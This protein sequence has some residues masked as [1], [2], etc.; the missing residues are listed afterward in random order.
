MFKSISPRRLQRLLPL[1]FVWLLWSL[2]PVLVWGQESTNVA[3]FD[4]LNSRLGAAAE[5]LLADTYPSTPTTGALAS[6]S[7]VHGMNAAPAARE[8]AISQGTPAPIASPRQH[9]A[10]GPERRG[11]SGSRVQQLRP[12]IDPI[13]RGEGI[14]ADFVAVALIESGGQAAALSPKGARGVWQLMPDTARRYGLVVTGAR[15]DRLDLVSATRAAARYLRDLHAL[16]GDWELVLAA[17]NAGEQAV[18]NAIQRAGSNRFAVLSQLRLLPTETRNYVPAVMGAR[19]LFKEA[20][21]GA[22]ESTAVAGL[23]QDGRSGAPAQNFNNR[24]VF[25][26]I[27]A[28]E[29]YIA[30]DSGESQN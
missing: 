18:Q 22:A 25:Y 4:E 21:G 11:Q 27:N 29:L 15:D 10:S 17:Y 8:P 13:L 16:F 19:G 2:S 9:A 12:V 1:S 20:R 7:T 5:R 28:P 24:K 26:A 30:A 3:L 14:P 6:P 23:P